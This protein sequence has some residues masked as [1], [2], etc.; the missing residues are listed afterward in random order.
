[1]RYTDFGAHELK[2]DKDSTYNFQ[3]K[4]VGENKG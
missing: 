4:K 2:R 1:M 3:I